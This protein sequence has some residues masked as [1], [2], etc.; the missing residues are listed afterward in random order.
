[1][2][3]EIESAV[4][5]AIDEVLPGTIDKALAESLAVILPSALEAVGLGRR[6]NDIE[7]RLKQLEEKEVENGKLKERLLKAEEGLAAL[8]RRGLDRESRQ[9]RNNFIIRGL[10]EEG[11]ETDEQTETRVRRF[12]D[13]HIFEGCGSNLS[14]ERTH[15][16]GEGKTRGLIIVGCSFYKQKDEIMKRKSALRFAKERF[17][18]DEDLPPEMRK[19]AAEFR[20]ALIP[21][22]R[23]AGQRLDL[24][25]PF[26]VAR[27]GQKIYTIEDLPE[28]RPEGMRDN[29]HRATTSQGNPRQR[30]PV[31]EAMSQRDAGEL[32][33]SGGKRPGESMSPQHSPL[34]K[35]KCAKT[36]APAKRGKFTA[37]Q[38]TDKSIKNDTLDK[39][40]KV[41]PFVPAQ[42][43]EH[44]PKKND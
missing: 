34:E 24:R 5:R 44:S 13:E 36:S 10:T 25:F 32:E 21:I 37:N 11:R 42:A 8:T 7:E 35:S 22:A 23:E 14:I 15:R 12:L 43:L 39:F 9:R 17:F 3:H 2:A 38:R 6:L 40:F 4:K 27:I 28:L 1:M 16:L 19:R 30:H 31:A 29:L 33:V 26:E 41:N 18:I 20:R